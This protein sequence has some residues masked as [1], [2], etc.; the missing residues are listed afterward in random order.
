MVGLG[1]RRGV[2]RQIK[3]TAKGEIKVAKKAI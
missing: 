3:K 2:R 1:R